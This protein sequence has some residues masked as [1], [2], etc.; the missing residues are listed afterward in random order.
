MAHLSHVRG[1]FF[2][3]DILKSRKGMYWNGV[4]RMRRDTRPDAYETTQV[5]NRGEHDPLNAQLLDAMQQGFAF[6]TVPLHR[7]LFKEL[8]DIG[9][10]TVGVSALR[11]HKSLSAC[12]GTA[13]STNRRHNDPAELFV[14]PGG[15][16]CG[17]LHGAQA[18]PNPHGIE[19][20]DHCFRDRRKPRVGCEVARIK[21]ITIA[22]LGQELLGFLRIVGERFGLQGEVHHP[23]DNDSSRWTEPEARCLVDRLSIEGV[24]DGQTYTLIGPWRFRIPLLGELDPE[25]GRMACI[26]QGQ[27]GITFDLLSDLSLTRGKIGFLLL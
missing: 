12:G 16:K 4:D 14:A 13:R 7:L 23:W 22:G 9:I 5:H 2:E 26:H 8:V 11:I 25:Y 20:I 6:R 21:A 10:A 19:V 27:F 24:I 1:L 17:A 3:C 18:H 15:E